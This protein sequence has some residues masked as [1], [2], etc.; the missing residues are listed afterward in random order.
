MKNF[1]LY[2]RIISAGT[3]LFLLEHARRFLTTSASTVVGEKAGL[4]CW[5]LIIMSF[6]SF[7]PGFACA[8]PYD[9]T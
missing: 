4:F 5:N 1:G 8:I 9:L 7:S 6:F 3:N 2:V